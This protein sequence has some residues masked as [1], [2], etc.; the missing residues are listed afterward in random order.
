MFRFFCAI[1]VFV[2]CFFP[3]ACFGVDVKFDGVSF[4]IPAGWSFQERKAY[5]NDVCIFINK[6][7]PSSLE[8]NTFVVCMGKSGD[9]DFENEIG[10]FSKERPVS[11]GGVSNMYP[12][13]FYKTKNKKI[14]YA[15]TA[16]GVSDENGAHAQG[17]EC[18]KS[19][20]FLNGVSFY[21]Y[22]EGF[23]HDFNMF[24]KIIFSLRKSP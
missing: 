20:V 18:F 10:F 14:Y 9:S 19:V 22:S 23:S 7:H 2:V 17:G 3:P 21:A 13:A 4:F 24:K 6:K 11:F 15:V 5:N 8:Q 16:C 1:G 12:A